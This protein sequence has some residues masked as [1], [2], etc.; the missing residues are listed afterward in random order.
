ME[1]PEN[2]AEKTETPL[3]RVRLISRGK[4]GR[5][6]LKR[7]GPSTRPRRAIFLLPSLFTAGN[8][9]CGVF[10]IFF[11]IQGDY[12][13]AALWIL[14]AHVLDGVDG[15]VARLTHTTSQFGVEFD[16]LA[17]V[18]SFGVAPAVLVYVFALA[19]WGPWGG[20]AP[21]L[22]AVCGALRLA[23]F[24]VQTLTAEKSY[25]TGLPIPAAAAMVAA[26]LFIFLML[27]LESSAGM[28]VAF[29]AVTCVLAALMVSNFRY[30]SL[31]QHHFKRRSTIWLLLSALAVVILTI[32]MWQIVLF[33]ALLLYTLSGPLLWLLAV[34]KRRRETQVLI[35]A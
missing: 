11:A 10:A 21:A 9:F 13:Q 3:R 12:A 30:P 1:D 7:R 20:V 32:A 6:R 24:N 17:D 25:F 23:R 15:A 29:I 5:R 33:T 31:K 35:Q 19:S 16:S 4:M 26:T 28:P 2:T 34:R 27:G 8:L 18:V 22:F 14:A